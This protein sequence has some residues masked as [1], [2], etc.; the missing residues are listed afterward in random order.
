MATT[1]RRRAI[2]NHDMMDDDYVDVLRT[3]LRNYTAP[4]RSLA[5]ILGP[6][7][8]DVRTVTSTSLIRAMP[9]LQMFAERGARMGILLGHRL[10]LAWSQLLQDQ[11]SLVV[12]NAGQDAAVLTMHIATVFKVLRAVKRKDERPGKTRESPKTGS[13][14]LRTFPWLYRNRSPT[15]AKRLES[16]HLME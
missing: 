15:F 11:P 12:S 8:S 1:T 7:M 5:T 3:W 16:K 9:L 2:A 14:S 13:H 10:E 4:S 6:L